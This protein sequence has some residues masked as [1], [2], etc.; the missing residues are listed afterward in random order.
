MGFPRRKKQFI[1]SHVQGALSRRIILH[2]LV[3]VVVASVVAFMLQV[4]ADPFRGVRA[5]L[6]DLWWSQGP[7]LLVMFFMLPV[8]VMDAVKLSNR[9]AGPIF[10]LRRAV[11]SIAEGNA[12]R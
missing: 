7:F 4:L 1:D 2:W 5:H 11:R 10:S 8:F 9:F 3:F 6:L 12:P